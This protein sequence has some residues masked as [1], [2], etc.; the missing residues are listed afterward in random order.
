MPHPHHIL[1]DRDET[2][3]FFAPSWTAQF[4]EHRSL[5][6][7]LHKNSEDATRNSATAQHNLGGMYR[8]GQGVEKDFKEAVKWYQKA[9]EQGLA[10][11]QYNLGAM[12][13]QGQGV[14]QDFKEAVKWWHKAAYQGFAMAQRN[15]GA[16]YYRGDGVLKDYVTS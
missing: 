7:H 13:R 11:A 1:S 16:I 5:C 12:Y 9:A 15:L 6:D 3:L 10:T 8:D 4:P 14:E 2:R